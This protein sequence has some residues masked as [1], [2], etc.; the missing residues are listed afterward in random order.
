MQGWLYELSSHTLIFQWLVHI[1]VKVTFE[2]SWEEQHWTVTRDHFACSGN[3]S[4]NLIQKD[5]S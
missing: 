3:I 4:N 1:P 5:L 2:N